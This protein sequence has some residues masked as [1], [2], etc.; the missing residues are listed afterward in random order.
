MSFPLMF[1]L[2]AAAFLLPIGL[3]AS[4]VFLKIA[5]VLAL[6]REEDLLA[7]L[8]IRAKRK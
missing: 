8:G 3:F 1:A 7:A 5:L 6:S 2:G 4:A